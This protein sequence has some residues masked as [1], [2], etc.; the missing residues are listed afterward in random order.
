MAL[1]AGE[2]MHEVFAAVRIWQLEHVQ[3]YPKHAQAVANR[4]FGADRWRKCLKRCGMG[5][6]GDWQTIPGREHLMNLC[7]EIL[8]SSEWIDNPSDTVRT[9]SNMELA[10]IH[11]IDER[12][13][14]MGNWPIFVEDIDNPKCCVGI[15]QVFDVVLSFTDNK[16]FRYIGTIDGL[17]RKGENGEWV[18]D[19]NKTAS[20]LDE[21][22]RMSFEMSHQV[23]GYCAASTTVFGFP[24]MRNRVTGCKVKPTN[25]GE[26]VIVIE[27]MPRTTDSI[28][29]WGSWLRD[30]AEMYEK[31]KDDWENAPRYTHSCNRY[32]RP[33]SLLAFC[34]DTPEGRR[35]AFDQ[36][37]IPA[38]KSPSERGVSDV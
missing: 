11:Y 31:F 38:S 23:T 1:E 17:V 14:W 4:I 9:M 30:T 16:K 33:C 28:L 29:R 13:P 36:Q 8:H 24:V 12:F 25:K 7:F 21:G 5:P 27:P 20:R 3:G 10:S 6:K 15:E 18:L 32:F 34:C 26:D 37:M 2:T 35:E 19:E 22:W